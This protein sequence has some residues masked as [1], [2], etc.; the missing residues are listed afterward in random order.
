MPFSSRNKIRLSVYFALALL[1]SCWG[2]P[3]QLSYAALTPLEIAQ[4]KESLS[5]LK[6]N[7]D[8]LATFRDDVSQRFGT[9]FAVLLNYTQQ[10][11]LRDN[12]DQ[13]KSRGVGYLN[14]E[15]EQQLWPGSEIFLEVESDNGAGIDKY[16]PS[17][18]V[19]N[20]NYGERIYIYVP[21]LYIEQYLFSD[22]VSFS[23]GKI[24]LSDWFDA[25]IAA[26]SADTQ[27]LSG[28]LVN[29]LTIPFPSKGLGALVSFRPYAW[30]YFQSG[31]STARASYTKTGL[32]D[33]FNSVFFINEFGVSPSF[34]TL[35]GNFR[36]IFHMNH[37]KL[38][39][40]DEEGERKDTFGYAI[41]F[42][43]EIGRGI[44]LFLR[45]GKDD[46]RVR[47]IKHFWS[48]GGQVTGLFPGRKADYLGVGVARSIMGDD[49]RSANEDTSARSET[50]Y[51]VYYNYSLNE[52]ISLAPS[53]QIVT[54]PNA[55][56]D[57][58]TAVVLGLRF[59]LSF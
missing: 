25:N 56:K 7:L 42:D 32:S 47:D 38:E 24:D 34:G 15:I 55:E 39:R 35:K 6:G 50:M 19:F 48:F 22:K 8:D 3:L 27:F 49:F 21:R 26:E 44:V 31:A 33:G 13:N 36:F 59:L 28:A 40:I 11:V 53:L 16:I 5:P 17:Y 46:E 23:F 30:A 2:I 29:N 4:E 41:S 54:N 45:Y 10:A 57:A 43:Q 51:E 58:K 37:E 52:V 12:E 20:S 1:L 14:L 18:S 9:E